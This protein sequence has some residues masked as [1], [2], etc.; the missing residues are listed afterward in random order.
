MSR[1]KKRDAMPAAGNEAEMRP[2][3]EQLFIEDPGRP[4]WTAKKLSP[5]RAVRF[6]C[7]LNDVLADVSGAI[8][9]IAFNDLASMDWSS[10]IGKAVSVLN[11][12]NYFELLS[13]ASGHTKEEIE[14]NEDKFNYYDA[15]KCVADFVELN[16]LGSVLKD[17]F[18]P[19]LNQVLP[20]KGATP[21]DQPSA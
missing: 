16:R 20:K 17:F 3:D 11:E 13:I 6:H 12:K 2:A 19:V 15:W 21:E 9:S 4:F 8:S 14:A 7:W 10:V 5:R 18:A 1:S